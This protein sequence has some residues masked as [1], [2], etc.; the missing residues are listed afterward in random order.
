V[1]TVHPL[2]EPLARTSSALLDPHLTLLSLSPVVQD[3]GY[4]IGDHHAS[5]TAV[6][7]RHAAPPHYPTDV[8]LF[9]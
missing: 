6:E 5:S 3:L 4:I 7:R 9:G 2:G 1:A 8:P